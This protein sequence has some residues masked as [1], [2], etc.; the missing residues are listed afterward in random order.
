MT[1]P[2][3]PGSEHRWLEFKHPEFA[4]NHRQ[5]A[6]TRDHYTGD[7]MLP[8]KIGTYLPQKAVGES[9][10]AWEHRKK[11]AD[12]TNLLAAA[13]DGIAG[14]L[15]SSDDRTNR[16]WDGPGGY[17]FGKIDD[18]R[19]LA[20]RLWRDAD[21]QGSPWLTLWKEAT[22]DLLLDSTFW[23]V[24]DTA[25]IGYDDAGTRPVVRVLPA[26]KVPNH[27]RDKI[28]L[29]AV[30]VEDDTE[31]SGSIEQESKLLERRVVYRREG[32]ER[33]QKE[34]NGIWRRTSTPEEGRYKYT[35]ASGAPA[36]PIFRVKLPL[37]RLVGWLL[38]RKNNAIFN[39]ESSR[40]NLID[41]CNNPR[42]N[43]VGDDTAYNAVVDQLQRGANALQ[44]RPG[45]EPHNYI[46]PSSEPATIATAVID[47][48]V[49]D[50]LRAAM[51]EYGDSAQQRTA[52]ETRQDVAQGM[53]A[54][55]G[56]VATALDAAENG[57]MWR[58]AQTDRP[59]VPAGSVSARVE[60]SNDFAVVDPEAAI[61]KLRERVFGKDAPVPLGDKARVAAARQVAEFLGLEHDEESLQQ[62]VALQGTLEVLKA[63]QGLPVVAAV[64]VQML[65]LLLETTR[66][67][68]ADDVVGPDG[69]KRPAATVKRADGT[70]VP[71]LEQIL[72]DALAMAEAEDEGARRGSEF[73]GAPAPFGAP[74]RPLA[75]A[76]AATAAAAGDDEDDE[77]EERE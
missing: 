32:W 74:A 63:Y 52:T 24:C 31:E 54:F 10:V 75:G 6:F 4:K 65:K 71:Q 53:G 66:L 35:A 44:Q 41:L 34:A 15:W 57:A 7:V 47:A 13:I 61:E 26:L 20:G 51:R 58:L 33:W 2:A 27:T 40:D 70:V 72:V 9:D 55:L 67:L 59:A 39:R 17:S 29:S 23:V 8:E 36:L 21:G 42:L 1:T 76:A 37:S 18:P 77:D 60:R 49:K 22:V 62:S 48:K 30:V 12:Y 50:F 73:L 19:S 25:Q 68:G 3:I 45:N 64:R 38:A 56:L 16:V 11:M 5:W 43:I 14:M 28:G 46:A 69:V